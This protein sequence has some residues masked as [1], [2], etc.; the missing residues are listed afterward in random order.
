M[1]TQT[2]GQPTAYECRVLGDIPPADGG[3][4]YSV[5]AATNTDAT[6]AGLCVTKCRRD[7]DP[8]FLSGN[9]CNMIDVVGHGLD[10]GLA[11]CCD[12]RGCKVD[13]SRRKR[14]DVTNV[15]NVP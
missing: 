4:F 8:L 3:R 11:V 10:I 9:L 5:M 13:L 2:Q 12:E 1:I 15:R 7:Q 6:E 14:D